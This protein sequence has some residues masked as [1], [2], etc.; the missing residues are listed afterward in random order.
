METG[1]SDKTGEV[2]EEVIGALT[3]LHASKAKSSRSCANSVF[4]I[5]PILLL[6]AYRQQAATYLIKRFG[7]PQDGWLVVVVAV[8]FTLIFLIRRAILWAGQIKPEHLILKRG[9]TTFPLPASHAQ[10]WVGL[11]LHG[12]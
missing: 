4:G 10:I 7:G 1:K 12:K 6:G 8:V 9:T 5:L 11:S 3:R 2:G